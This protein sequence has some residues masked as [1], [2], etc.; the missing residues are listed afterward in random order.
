[1]PPGKFGGI[2][3]RGV[4]LRWIDID[5]HEF[6]AAGADDLVEADLVNQNVIRGSGARDSQCRVAVGCE[7]LGARESH[8][9][10]RQRGAQPRLETDLQIPGQVR[11][12]L[13]DQ[14]HEHR[15]HRQV[16]PLPVQRRAVQD[17]PAGAQGVLDEQR[18]ALVQAHEHPVAVQGCKRHVA[19]EPGPSD[20]VHLHQR[21]VGAVQRAHHQELAFPAAEIGERLE[22]VP[23]DRRHRKSRRAT[24]QRHQQAAPGLHVAA[25]HGGVFVLQH[26]GVGH[27]DEHVVFQ[28]AVR[29]A[30]C[31][32]RFDAV[33][34]CRERAERGC[35][36]G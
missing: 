35:K 36:K 15:L 28:G 6:R 21:G 19:V 9:P 18:P 1:M 20:I 14:R 16:V 11:G 31:G 4:R 25:Q 33:V 8:G 26:A 23:G 29:E 13:R 17:H 30:R 32:H 10:R 22:F 34:L 2:D 5:G 24:R 27:H 12:K 3:C 7:H